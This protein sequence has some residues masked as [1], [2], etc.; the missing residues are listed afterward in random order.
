M[1][2]KDTQETMKKL[3][4]ITINYNNKSGLEQT[5]KSV[6]NQNAEKHT[7]H[8]IID[9][10][11]NDGS[12]DVIDENKE[13]FSYWCSEKDNG[14]YH[15]MN[16]GIAHATGEY[17]LFLNSGDFLEPEVIATVLNELTGTDIIYGDII[18]QT[19]NGERQT[20]VYPDTL[21]IEYM[22]FK[23]IG[24][25]ATFFRRSLFQRYAYNE[26]LKIVS[27]WEFLFKKIIMESHSTRHIPLF[28]STFMTDGIS[29]TSGD[30]CDQERREC[31]TRLLSPAIYQEM[32]S[33]YEFKH[34]PYISL[35]S[36]IGDKPHIRRHIR[37]YIRFLLSVNHIAG[38][39]YK[40]K[41]KKR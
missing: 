17:L 4:I 9:G 34:N 19:T 2:G 22:F 5:I 29:S 7:E 11:S 30:L 13:H 25:P 1:Q 18:F 31:L 8:I 10:G 26:S 12:L 33:L 3:S 28:I 36:E 21:S 6:V 38:L 14:I 15:A 27:D 35:F 20:M 23:A 32:C 40:R 37:K 39:L 41:S 24:H 16:K